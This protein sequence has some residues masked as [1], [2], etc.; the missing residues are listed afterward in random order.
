MKR[1]IRMLK[2]K[3]REGYRRRRRWRDRGR[4]RGVR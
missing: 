2:E 4:K 1:W 3:S